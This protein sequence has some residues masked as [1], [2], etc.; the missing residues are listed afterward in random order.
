MVKRKAV[1]VSEKTTKK[2][3]KGSESAAKTMMNLTSPDTV[4]NSL[5]F[6][7]TNKEFADTYWEKKPLYVSREAGKDYYGELFS[8]EIMK[9]MLTDHELHYEVDVN[10][11]RYVN[12]EKE[13]LNGDGGQMKLDDISSLMTEKQATFQFHQPQRYSDALWNVIEKL[14]SH[15]GSLVGANVYITPKDA[16]GLAPHCDDV[17]IF[18]LQ[19]EGKKT[20]KL[21]T[22]MVELSR[23]YTQDLPESDIGEPFMELTLEPGDLLY[24]PRGTIHHAKT[25]GDSHSTHL[26]ISTYQQNT[27]GDFMSIAVSQ[28]IENALEDD[29]TVRSG[30][31][32]NYTSFLGTEKNMSKYVHEDEDT[33]NGV[34]NRDE[35][36]TPNGVVKNEKVKKGELPCNDNDEKVKQFKEKIKAHLSKLIDHIDVNTAADVMS[37][38]FIA[39]RLPPHGHVIKDNVEEIDEKT[40]PTLESEIRLRFPNHVR[41]VFH[42]EENEEDDDDD[43]DDD[44]DSDEEMEEDEEKPAMNGTSET[45]K[46]AD[47][48]KVKKTKKTPSKKTPKK[49]ITKSTTDDDDD[50]DDEDAVVEEE[51]CIKVLHSLNNPQETHMAGDA[52]PAEATALKFPVHFAYA[53]DAVFNSNKEFIRVK[54]II[55]EDDEE[56]LQLVTS[57]YSDDLI[58]VK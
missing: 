28:A 53:L 38:D 18:I 47:D 39:S 22:P 7:T 49:S 48:E 43:L 55:L 21:H 1:S 17:E 50:L 16:Q 44:E 35:K 3:K 10:V 13:H 26:T 14:E 54:D 37:M 19:L 58:E 31:P 27:W 2:I 42:D 24:L 6:P 12:G 4:M 40:V 11:C 23:D 56:K 30:L 33:P 29:V 57:L 20:W 46:K 5:I 36:S 51:P 9:Q 8:L 32:I 34:A 41:I 25:T 45:D 15:F 52:G